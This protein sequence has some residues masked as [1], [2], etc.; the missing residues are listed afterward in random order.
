MPQCCP[1]DRDH[2]GNCDR[3]PHDDTPIMREIRGVSLMREI[4]EVREILLLPKEERDRALTE[5]AERLKARVEAYAREEVTKMLEAS[6][7]PDDEASK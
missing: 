1:R 3:H 4:Q 7:P 2:D 5:R 6:L